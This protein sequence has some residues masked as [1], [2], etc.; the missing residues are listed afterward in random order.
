MATGMLLG[1]EAQNTIRPYPKLS[2]DHIYKIAVVCL[3][4]CLAIRMLKSDFF[5]NKCCRRE[6]LV[7]IMF[8]TIFCGTNPIMNLI[9]TKA[10]KI[11]ITMPNV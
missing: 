10:V 5:L 4:T 3:V 6:H 8:E 2:R 11:L 1:N 7:G 9:Q